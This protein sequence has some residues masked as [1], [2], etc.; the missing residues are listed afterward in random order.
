[1]DDLGYRDRDNYYQRQI[2]HGD[3]GADVDLMGI[4]TLAGFQ[5]WVADWRLPDLV[6]FPFLRSWLASYPFDFRVIPLLFV[7]AAILTVGVAAHLH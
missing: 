7:N 4:A 3:L 2:C 1:M 6:W 5:Q